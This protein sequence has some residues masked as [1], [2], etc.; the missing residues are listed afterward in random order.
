MSETPLT[1]PSICTQGA[2]PQ[3]PDLQAGVGPGKDKSSAKTQ[4]CLPGGGRGPWWTTHSSGNTM[5]S[6]LILRCRA[7][8]KSSMNGHCG[9]ER[10]RMRGPAP[11]LAG[12]SSG[13]LVRWGGPRLTCSG[14][15]PQEMLN[16]RGLNE[17]MTTTRSKACTA[18]A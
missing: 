2:A 5:A 13:L 15:S 1:S 4:T 11:Q 12:G 14:P 3:P 7:R 8:M 17:C 6:F 18:G 16:K 10:Q 9:G